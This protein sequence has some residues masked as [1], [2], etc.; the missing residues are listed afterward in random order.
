MRRAKKLMVHR[1]IIDE[2][3]ESIQVKLT[4]SNA[5]IDVVR[6]FLTDLLTQKVPELP[7]RS[8]TNCRSSTTL[9]PRLRTTLQ[10]KAFTKT[11]EISLAGFTS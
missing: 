5:Y 3:D 1:Q 10:A 2:L 6:Q 11:V 9:R 8:S 4:E 7:Q